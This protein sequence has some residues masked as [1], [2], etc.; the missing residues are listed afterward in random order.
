MKRRDFLKISGAGALALSCTPRKSTAPAGDGEMVLRTNP[1]NG[2]RTSLLGYGCMRWPMV[3]DEDGRDVIDQ[4]AVNEMVDYAMAHG[5]NYYDTSPVY[6]QGQSEI[7]AGEALK[8]YPRESYYL[9]TK[10]SNF[11]DTSP[12]GSKRMFEE[13][14]KN[15]NTDYIDYYLLHALGSNGRRQEASRRLRP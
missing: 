11:G 1:N 8:R 4:A 12:E 10:L 6:L 13:S 9:A 7:A 2:D 14:L 15:L 5:I 3:K